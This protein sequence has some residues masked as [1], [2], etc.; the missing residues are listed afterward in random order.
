VSTRSGLIPILVASL[1]LA[2]PVMARERDAKPTVLRHLK[3]CMA[4]PHPAR[5]RCV[6]FAE[7]AC[8]DYY[9]GGTQVM[10]NVC[11]LTVKNAARSLVKL[12]TSS[13]KSE[14]AQWAMDMEQAC[15]AEN[16]I[17]PNGTAYGQADLLCQA[18]KLVHSRWVRPISLR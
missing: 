4:S 2:A 12:R 16:D 17:T 18:D 15:I 6:D 9:G 10:L 13:D 8:A 5:D 7:D 11:A 3:A 14:F 1:A